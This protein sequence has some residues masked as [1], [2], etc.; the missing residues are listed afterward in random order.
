MGSKRNEYRIFVGNSEGK[1]PQGGPSCRSKD[2]IKWISEREDKVIW[3]VLIWL[4]IGT[5]GGF[6]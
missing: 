5:S 4:R 1:R 3:T 2:N 6:L